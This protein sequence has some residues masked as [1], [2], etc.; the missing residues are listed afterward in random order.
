MKIQ[1]QVIFV[2]GMSLAMAS[3]SGCSLFKKTSSDE[4]PDAVAAPDA[5]TDAVPVASADGAAPADPAQIA[6]PAD[7]PATPPAEA[8]PADAPPAT[9]PAAQVPSAVTET[10][11]SQPTGAPLS[12]EAI[13]YAVQSGDT[14]MK[15]AFETYGD[16]YRWK[17]IYEWNKGTLSSP[18]GVRKGMRL[19]LEKPATSV[20]IERNGDKYLIKK[21]DTLGTISDEVYGTKAKWKKIY[22]NNRQLIKDPNKIFAGF[23][24]YYVPDPSFQP[25]VKSA[26]LA[27][28]APSAPAPAAAAPGATQEGFS[29]PPADG[30]RNPAGQ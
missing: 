28:S 24:L 14:L 9:Q 15:I 26:P 18:S 19:K 6:A 13:D 25:K 7:A 8:I 12:G 10:A 21:G 4:S 2:L 27:R 3:V 11:T 17:D 20:V 1:N 23:S 16:L 30:V 29:A 22:E 5:A